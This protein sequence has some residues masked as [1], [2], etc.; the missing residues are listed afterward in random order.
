MRE[1]LLKMKTF[2]D[3]LIS[4]G[5]QITKQD[6]I[7]YILAGL[8]NEYDSVV[9]MSLPEQFL[10]L[11]KSSQHFCLLMRID[12]SSKQSTPMGLCHLQT[13]LNSSKR[14]PLV[15]NHSHNKVEISFGTSPTAVVE[16]E[17]GTGVIADLS[18]NFVANLVIRSA[19]A[20]IGSTLT[21][22]M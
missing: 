5:Q 22:L 20:T 6:Q 4:V 21:F 2:T 10:I 7:V 17:D 12:L 11:F 9:V 19:H 18:V 13:S 16:A 15:A 14:S 8:G 1:Y 3:V